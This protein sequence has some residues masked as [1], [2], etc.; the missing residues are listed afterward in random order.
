MPTTA[1]PRRST[2]PAR[3]VNSSSSSSRSP[4]PGA[5]AIPPCSKK[6]S[7]SRCA[8]STPNRR[9][10]P[11][12]EFA[13]RNRLQDPAGVVEGQARI[14]RHRAGRVGM[15]EIDQEVGAPAAVGKELGVDLAIVEARHR[16]AI[17]PDRARRENEVGALQGAVAKRGDLAAGPLRLAFEPADR[18][19]I[20]R[21]DPRQ[22]LVEAHVVGDD[23]RDR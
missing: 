6:R 12:A 19:R 18:A 2:P 22:E 16:P 8:T 23:D 11:P 15:A 5:A 4:W 7:T 9:T 10:A 1:L 3:I 20:V 13:G 21:K 14:A 17:E